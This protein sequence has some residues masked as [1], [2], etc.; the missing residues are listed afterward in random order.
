MPDGNGP[1]AT[2]FQKQFGNIIQTRNDD[3]PSRIVTLAAEKASESTRPSRFGTSLERI[4][5][6]SLTR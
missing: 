4:A 6:E 5:P 1:S 3:E 2:P